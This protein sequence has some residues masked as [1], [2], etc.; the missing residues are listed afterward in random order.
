V[1]LK[2]LSLT[3]SPPPVGLTLRDEGSSLL[4][5]H[6][7]KQPIGCDAQLAGVLSGG[8]VKMSG[9][10][11]VQFSRECPPDVRWDFR[12]KGNT[13]VKSEHTDTDTLGKNFFEGGQLCWAVACS[14]SLPYLFLS[15]L[16]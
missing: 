2:S 11:I 9:R 6:H 10:N 8:G 13:R 3:P 12:G 16:V 4:L 15:I 7:N 14:G 1:S 5:L